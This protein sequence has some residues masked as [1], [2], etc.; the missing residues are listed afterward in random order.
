MQQANKK[1]IP[2]MKTIFPQGKRN[3]LVRKHIDFEAPKMKM[4][5]G[6]RRGHHFV[7]ET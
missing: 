7:G 5:I 1:P 4:K 6:L 3:R 2:V